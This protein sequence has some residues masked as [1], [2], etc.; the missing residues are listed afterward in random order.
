M[1][2]KQKR[3]SEFDIELNGS[4]EDPLYQ[5]EIDEHRIDKLGQ[6][7]TQVAVIVLCLIAAA[8]AAAYF[9]VRKKLQRFDSS[10][11]MRVQN[12]SENLDATFSSL[13]VQVAKLEDSL[14]KQIATFQALS[15]DLDKKIE[16]LSRT[17]KSLRSVKVSKKTLTSEV[18][19]IDTT[20]AGLRDDM[21]TAAGEFR[22][23]QEEQIAQLQRLSKALTEATQDI[24]KIES[25]TADLSALRN[26]IKKFESTVQNERKLYRT[27]LDKLETDIRARIL[28][29]EKRIAGVESSPGS[30]IPPPPKAASPAA[31][32]SPSSQASGQIVEQDIK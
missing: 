20:L 28:A 24:D 19:K 1:T 21:A 5:S 16:K 12:L 23:Y 7:M 30:S 4:D 14:N 17:D 8:M 2:M 31:P 18:N 13:S 11:T 29:L 25:T 3:P 9:D 22:Q 10:G 32:P 6:R 26:D 27:T 15:A